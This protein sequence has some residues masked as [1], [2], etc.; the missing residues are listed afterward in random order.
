MQSLL[1]SKLSYL[2]RNLQKKSL[3][4]GNSA[5]LNVKSFVV[6]FLLVHGFP[7]VA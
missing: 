1:G 6:V 4:A 2:W 5:L 3:C 7:V